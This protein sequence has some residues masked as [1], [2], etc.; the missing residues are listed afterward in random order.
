MEFPV[1]QDRRRLVHNKDL[2]LHRKRLGNFYHLLLGQTDFFNQGSCAQLLSKT[3]QQL[4]GPLF[5][6][7]LVKPTQRTVHHFMAQENIF[8]YC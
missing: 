7:P 2:R 4:L 5:H 8:R 1:C 3:F 6:G